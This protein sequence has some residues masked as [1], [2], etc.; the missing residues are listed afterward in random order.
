MEEK[1]ISENELYHSTFGFRS[2]LQQIVEKEI[3]KTKNVFDE[4][5]CVIRD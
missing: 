2:N 3:R 4:L 5:A 1:Q